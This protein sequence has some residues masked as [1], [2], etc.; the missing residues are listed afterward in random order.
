V[1]RLKKPVA[2]SLC[3]LAWWQC[4]GCLRKYV[5]V[6]SSIEQHCKPGWHALLLW[7]VWWHTEIVVFA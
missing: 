1:K 4:E 6:S 2:D 5:N 3:C 7:C